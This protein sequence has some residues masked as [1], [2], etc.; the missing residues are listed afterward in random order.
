M[1]YY[2]YYK[3]NQDQL[4]IPL[5]RIFTN[6]D[7][8]TATLP[9]QVC[10]LRHTITNRTNKPVRNILPLNRYKTKLHEF[11]E[12]AITFLNSDIHTHY[13]T[14]FIPKASGGQR[15]INAPDPELMVFLRE[16]KDFFQ[17]TI[18]VLANDAAYAYVPNRDTTTALAVHQQNHSRWF[19]KLD[20]HHFFP[21]CNLEFIL[22][23]L[24]QVYPFNWFFTE[25]PA[26]TH[27]EFIIKAATLNNGLPQGTPLSP[28]LT[29][30]IMVPIDYQIKQKLQDLHQNFVYTRY[31]DDLLISSQ[32]HFNPDTIIRQVIQPILEETPLELN[33]EKTRNGSVAGRN[34]NL[35]LMLN[36]DNDITIGY[37]KKHTFKAILFNYF[38][39]FA[40]NTCWQIEHLDHLNGIIA[41]Y[42]KIE[43]AKI[44]SLIRK[45]EIKFG[46]NMKSM[47]KW[48]YKINYQGLP[49]GWNFK[50]L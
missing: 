38:K 30:M 29:N 39:D 2:T 18:H 48:S 33:L 40:S 50:P 7:E 17:N 9:E 36:K 37:R 43:P 47:I 3:Y 46:Q 35:G 27:L 28:F 22:K 14:F 19:L 44:A 10:T 23:Q 41:Y 42:R 8:V 6:W 24:E 25:Q 20:L 12:H 15:E 13:T 49:T 16:V 11:S 32:T 31:A 5:D 21:S 45:Y 4:N 34:W 1:Y 26:R